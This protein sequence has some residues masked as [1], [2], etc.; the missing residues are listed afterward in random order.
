MEAEVHYNF[1]ENAAFDSFYILEMLLL[2]LPLHQRL[3]NLMASWQQI[4][5]IGIEVLKSLKEKIQ[6]LWKSMDH[7]LLLMRWISC[8]GEMA[9]LYAEDLTVFVRPHTPRFQPKR[10]QHL[11]DINRDDYDSWYGLTPDA[12]R[13]LF[14]HWR[15]P[16]HLQSRT[17]REIFGGE[18]C[19]II[20]LFHLIKGTTYT[21]MA[22]HTFGGDPRTFSRMFDVMVDHLYFKFYNKISGIS[23]DQWIPRYLETCRSL[24]HNSLANGALYEREYENGELV[25]ET[26]IEHHFDFDT[27]RIFGFLDDVALPTARPSS[28]RDTE[29]AHDVQRAFYSGYLRKH[30]LK[31]QVVW[32]P[33]GL[34]GSVYITELRQNDNG[35]QNLSGL[36]DYLLELLQGIFIGGLFPCLYCDGIFA[37]LATILPRFTNPT[38]EQHLI[39]MR[40][41]SPRECIE[42]LF[43]DFKNLSSLYEAT[44]F[45]RLRIRGVRVRRMFLV[46]FFI[47][48]CYY[49]IRGSRSMYFGYLPP[50][51]E[52]YLPL[53]EELS[54]PP[55]VNLGQVWDYGTPL[56]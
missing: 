18:E 51:L 39:N 45:Q 3:S 2:L 24:I 1:A 25:D 23:L 43:A 21:E 8:Y 5:G 29:S 16:E 56:N 55:A 4:Q 19:V 50:T 35:V 20:F 10:Y 22:R 33:I 37:I 48:N 17:N 31:A 28:A 52:E 53:G 44:R 27:F 32:L 36:N 41:A 49:C 42:H 13:R 12:F 6:Q 46:S 38:P 54:P 40:L 7:L 30:G 11:S 14:V 26:Y 47:L 15:I 9:M 34:I